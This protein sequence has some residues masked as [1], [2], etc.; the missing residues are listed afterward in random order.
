[1]VAFTMAAHEQHFVLS[2]F[3]AVAVQSVDIVGETFPLCLFSPGIKLVI[4]RVR[5]VDETI[6]GLRLVMVSNGHRLWFYSIWA[7]IVEGL[8]VSSRVILL[9]ELRNCRVVD[10]RLSAV[11]IGPLF[12]IPP[13]AFSPFPTKGGGA[14]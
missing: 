14:Q 12:M 5:P 4:G 6:V 9:K 1:M 10:I 11:T 8:W 2:V 7:Y 3:I 13:P